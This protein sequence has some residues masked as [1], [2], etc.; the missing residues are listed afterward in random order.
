MSFTSFCG[1]K[2]LQN[3]ISPILFMYESKEVSFHHEKFWFSGD[4]GDFY[5]Y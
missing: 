2:S 1:G 5:S 4:L 3:V